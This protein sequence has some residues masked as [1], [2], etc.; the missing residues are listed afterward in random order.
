MKSLE[1]F[2]DPYRQYLQLQ[3]GVLYNHHQELQSLQTKL[4]YRLQHIEALLQ[5]HQL[6]HQLYWNK[7]TPQLLDQ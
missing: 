2:L 4:S 3:D 1:S 7:R 6:Q 5:N